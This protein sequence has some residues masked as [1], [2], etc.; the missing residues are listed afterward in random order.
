M[1]E[2]ALKAPPPAAAASEL[3]RATVEALAGHGPLAEHDATFIERDAQQER[4]ETGGEQRR[5]PRR[6]VA[7]AD[8]VRVREAHSGRERRDD[9]GG[10][11]Q[12]EQ[13]QVGERGPGRRR[14]PAG[15]REH[16]DEDRACD[17]ERQDDEDELRP[18]RLARGAEVLADLLETQSRRIST[19][20]SGGQES[21]MGHR[22]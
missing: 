4:G 10:C 18:Q 13:G 15:R 17:A 5:R 16:Q 2:P 9:V 22:S 19:A 14:E 1:T 3:E 8:P 12:D 11:T 20:V 21:V 6:M 7:S